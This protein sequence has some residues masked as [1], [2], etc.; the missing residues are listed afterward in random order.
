VE[1][2]PENEEFK[3]GLGRCRE[4]LSA[5]AESI[6]VSVGAKNNFFPQKSCRTTTFWLRYIPEASFLKTCLRLHGEFAPMQLWNLRS[7]W[8]LGT[9]LAPTRVLKN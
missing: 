7:S 4:S 6:L 1:Q 8:C 5:W 2:D 3:E 9:K